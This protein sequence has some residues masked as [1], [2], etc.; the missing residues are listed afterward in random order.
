MAPLL[1]TPAQQD[2]LKRVLDLLSEHFDAA[3]I[4]VSADCEDR[5]SVVQ[6]AYHGSFSTAVGLAELGKLNIYKQ[7]FNPLKQ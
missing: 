2:A 4:I 5:T 7:A 1:M 6:H 3:L